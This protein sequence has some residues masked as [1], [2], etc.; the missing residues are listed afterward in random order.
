MIVTDKEFW[1]SACSTRVGLT[2][3]EEHAVVPSVK[4]KCVFPVK[5]IKYCTRVRRT[6]GGKTANPFRP[7]RFPLLLMLNPLFALLSSRSPSLQPAAFLGPDSWAAAWEEARG[8]SR[9][10]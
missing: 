8:A 2:Q 9:R 6:R 1:V 4:N 5:L 3:A 7:P 10:L